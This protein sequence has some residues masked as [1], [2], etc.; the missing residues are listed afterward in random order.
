[1]LRQFFLFVL[2]SIPVFALYNGSPTLPEMPENNLFFNENSP[3]SA[4]TSYEVDFL[5][6]RK[7]ETVS[8]SDGSL[9]SFFQGAEIAWG[10]IDRVEVYMLLG[11]EKISFSANR[12]GKNREIQTSASFGGDIG[13]RSIIAFWGETKLGVDA[14]YFYAWPQVADSSYEGN[15][16]QQWQVGLALSQE[17]FFFT[18]Y[19]GGKV[20]NMQLNLEG[21]QIKNSNPFGVF[22]GLGIAGNKGVFLDLE[23]RFLDDYA[24]S[25]VA[26]F[27][28]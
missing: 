16:D 23:A 12:G 13:V 21:I 3:F 4:K 2:L 22:V 7:V 18:P 8:Y 9:H 5:L 1:M 27:R 10:F 26:G 25:G 24:L 15:K 14:K 20:S 6:G 19:I 17:F 28:F 11:V